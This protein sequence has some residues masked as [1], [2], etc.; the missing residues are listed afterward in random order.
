MM[1][2]EN[3]KC[4]ACLWADKCDSRTA[5]IAECDYYEPA[6][7]AETDALAEDDYRRDLTERQ[8]TYMEIVSEQDE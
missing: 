8:N 6:D 4:R 7:E 1:N 5:D 2:T 3:C